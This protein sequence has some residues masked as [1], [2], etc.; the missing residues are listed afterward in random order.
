MNKPIK[1]LKGLIII[2]AIVLPILVFAQ[3]NTNVKYNLIQPLPG[4]QSVPDF[5][6]FISFF[7]PFLLGLAGL[8]SLIQIV[9]GGIMRAVSGGN[10]SAVGD[11]NDMIWQAILGLLLALSA[12]LILNTINPDLVNLKFEPLNIQI[13]PPLGT[14]PNPGQQR[15][16]LNQQ[17]S[18]NIGCEPPYE[19]SVSTSPPTCK[20]PTVPNSKKPGLNQNCSPVTG[21]DS[22]HTPPLICQQF[23]SGED[24]YFKCVERTPLFGQNHICTPQTEPNGGCRPE[25]KCR[26]NSTGRTTCQP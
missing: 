22:T 19:C 6:T 24:A 8:L 13:A 10:P 18:I 3:D 26:L 16:G 17:C 21:C 11:A 15:P 7:I 20:Q 9:R 1:I 5:P 23:G 2:S 14:T 4:V 12:Y 25:L